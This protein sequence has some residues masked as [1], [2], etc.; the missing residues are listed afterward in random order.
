MFARYAAPGFLLYVTTSRTLMAVRFDQR[1]K[2][3]VGEPTV[4]ADG[5]RLGSLGS[6]DLCVAGQTLIYGTG[7]GQGKSELVWVTRDGRTQSVDS[8]WQGLFW[9]PT[10]SPDGTR[11]AAEAVAADSTN[12]WI[13]R[14]DDGPLMRL[15]FDG[16]QNVAPAWTP[17]SR[18]ITFTSNAGGSHN[19][20]MKR[21]DGS[22]PPQLLLRGATGGGGTQWSADGKWLVFATS[23]TG[24]SDILG[25]RRDSDTAAEKM[26]STSFSE[27]PPELSPD[28]RWLA[29]A[30]D[31]TGR[32]EIY[33]VPFPN[34]RAAKWAVSS[35][36]GREPTWAHNG[37]E[38]F[39][40]DGDGNMVTVGV[41]TSPTFAVSSPSTL[42]SAAQFRFGGSQPQYAVAPDDRRFLMIRPFAGTSSERLI[43]VENW[44]EE[45]RNRSR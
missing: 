45:L 39:Y 34:T 23:R 37:R 32:S 10:I 42:F 33:V 28:G 35:R 12:I 16:N 9:N 29:Y 19:L 20:W 8:T 4:V 17:D 40:R 26:L 24:G 30:S 18:F 41:R 2:K 22:A 44:A 38:I 3:I 21:A 27:A 43:V 36:G 7:T 15:T 25:F 1:A 6:A 5:L 14:L 31:E 13:K 11:V